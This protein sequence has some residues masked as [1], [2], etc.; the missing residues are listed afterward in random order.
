MSA[1]L[2]REKIIG[3][4]ISFRVNRIKSDATAEELRAVLAYVEHAL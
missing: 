2:P 1:P 4:A 3:K